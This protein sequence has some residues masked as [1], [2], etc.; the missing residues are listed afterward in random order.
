[1]ER[2]R[3]ERARARRDQ[4]A[5]LAR[6]LQGLERS[7]QAFAA[8]GNLFA[9]PSLSI[10][11][12][13]R[14]KPARS[15]TP[16]ARRDAAEAWRRRCSAVFLDLLRAQQRRRDAAARAPQIASFGVPSAGLLARVPTPAADA[17]TAYASTADLLADT[18]EVVCAPTTH[19]LTREEMIALMWQVGERCTRCDALDLS[20]TSH[21]TSFDSIRALL[22]S[23]GFGARLRVFAARRCAALDDPGL[24]VL[25]DRCFALEVVDLSGCENI[26]DVGLRF[27]CNKSPLKAVRLAGCPQVTGATLRALTGALSHKRQ[28]ACRDLEVLDVSCCPRLNDLGLESFGDAGC[29]G[30]HPVFERLGFLNLAS[31]GV[32]AGARPRVSRTALCRTLRGQGRLVVL[33]LA[34][35]PLLVDDMTCSVLGANCAFLSSL[36]LARCSLVTNLGLSHVAVGCRRIQCLDLTGLGRLTAHGLLHLVNKRAATLV[37]LNLTG[38]QGSMPSDLILPLA[39]K[40]PYAVKAESFYGFKPVDD[41]LHQKL[42]DQEGFIEAAAAAS[43]QAGVRGARDRARVQLLRRRMAV[44]IQHKWRVCRERRSLHARG[45]RF[46]ARWAAVRVL[47]QNVRIVLE[48]WAYARDEERRGAL[49]TLLKT[50]GRAATRIA[51]VYRGHFA[52]HSRFSRCADVMSALRRREERLRRQRAVAAVVTLQ[53]RLRWRIRWHTVRVDAEEAAQRRRDCLLAKRILTDALRIFVAKMKLWRL[54]DEWNRTH[55]RKYLAVVMIQCMVRCKLSRKLLRRKRWLRHLGI[56]RKHEAASQIQGYFVRSRRDRRAA[57]LLH[58]TRQS[59]AVRIQA[60]TRSLFVGHYTTFSVNE[61][62]LRWK[63]KASFEAMLAVQNQA[64]RVKQAEMEADSASDSDEEWEPVVNEETG[65]HGFFSLKRNAFR[66]DPTQI[67]L[68]EKSLVGRKIYCLDEDDTGRWEAA[69]IVAY[70]SWKNKWKIVW[71]N[72]DGDYFWCN[73]RKEHA[74]VMMRMNDPDTG[75]EDPLGNWIMLK[76]LF[77]GRREEH[78]L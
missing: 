65:E 12:R 44:V 75:E 36:C 3:D 24:K 37:L 27:L 58:Y 66:V 63:E 76:T 67:R 42:L 57:L 60:W 56:K 29:T 11:R 23:P 32:L 41:V 77:P 35:N 52:R 21:N 26:S 59:A 72:K 30:P 25:A 73:L 78:E 46:E 33:N 45:R 74:R 6:V 51:A 1:M 15:S 4:D 18:T 53:R 64:Q 2:A 49:A 50:M 19:S 40:L 16:R 38:L 5:T 8:P 20:G 70:N 7:R 68:W 13:R 61:L 28:G 10:F 62:E 48:R 69:A 31:V 55:Q 22:V 14:H 43:V 34:H 39:S 9:A 47:Q 71:A 17:T 54:W